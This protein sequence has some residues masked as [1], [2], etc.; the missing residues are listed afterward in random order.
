MALNHIKTVS[1]VISEFLETQA[2][3]GTLDA[4][5]VAA[6]NTL[7]KHDDLSKIKLLRKLEEIRKELLKA[8]VANFEGEGDDKSSQD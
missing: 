7:R 6:V 4:D 8:Q 5:T 3:D 1:E 2:A